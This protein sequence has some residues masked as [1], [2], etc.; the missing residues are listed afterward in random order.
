MQ[1]IPSVRDLVLIG[2]GHAHLSVLRRFA[3]RPLPG[4]RLT[5]VSRASQSPYSGM[6]PGFIAGHYTAP[7]MHFDL[8]RLAHQAR[9]RFI[10]GEVTGLDPAANRIQLA[11]RP[12]L[13]FDLLSLNT[14]STPALP[15]RITNDSRLTPV[16]PIDAFAHR[17]QAIQ[18][19]V[20]SSKTACHVGVIGGGAGG[21]ELVLAM[22]HRLQA[23]RRERGATAD[24]LAFTLICADDT[25]L[26]SHNEATRAAFTRI[27]AARGITVQTGTRVEEVDDD[28]VRAADG[29][30]FSFDEILWVTTAAPAPWFHA[31][32]LGT[33]VH[34]YV[35]VGTDLRSV[36]H[37]SVFAAGDCAA[38]AG[39]PRPKSGVHAVRQGAW[40]AE[41]L[42]RAL[43]GQPLRH[44]IPQQEALAILATG[45]RHAVATR[46]RWSVQGAW[47]WR[48]KDWIDRR[49]MRKFQSLPALMSSANSG[50]PSALREE[51]SALGPLEGRCGGCGAK[52]AASTLRSALCAS[53]G[54]DI[55]M[56]FDDAAVSEFPAG[57]LAVQS[58]DGF[59]SFIDDPWLF[60][61]ITAA[62]ALSDLYAMGA[63]PHS[64]LA[65]V[66]LPVNGEDITRRDLVQLTAGARSVLGA[67]GAALVGGHTAEGAEMSLAFSVTGFAS[68]G[69]LRTKRAPHA[70][71]V[72]ILTKALG[73]GVLL[74]ADMQGRCFS[75]WL[76][77]A[78]SAMARDNGKAG[79]VLGHY[80]VHAL[81]D[82]TGFGVA[83]HLGEMLEGGL[84]H[85]EIDLAALPVLEG[86][87]D[88]VAAGIRST[89]H[90]RNEHL[91]DSI[92]LK[93]A[94]D[95]PGR[96][97]LLFDPQTS[98][99]LLAALPQH[100]AQDCLRA[101][102][103]A[104]CAAAIIGEVGSR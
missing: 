40:L 61:G 47:V 59:R 103:D 22:Q 101:L 21:V 67:A 78:L 66:T 90:V 98:G 102:Q 48:W 65:H 86:A 4:V 56:A 46:G 38:I 25:L 92:T 64:A 94:A 71:D 1:H 33:D 72:L 24:T 18:T 79:R 30:S 53:P 39:H 52:V 9:C 89:L 7:E 81:T 16:K 82:V 3:M 6:L 45:P 55:G 14:G 93:N 80:S 91:P 87:E 37:A 70:G 62:H 74:A 8:R 43:L 88:M 95:H 10:L 34:G 84:L 104:G 27:L 12:P 31:S 77:A 5:L 36:T 41:N 19:R 29:R 2:G 96:Y 99:G 97:A 100:E 49:F 54:P 11:D 20:L 50:L 15:A 69:A 28:R 83:G 17:W 75:P 35:Q 44:E 68:R 51:I 76:D 26:P 42:Q 23:A 32:G 57:A 63:T 73:T 60:G 85:A 58:L 13:E